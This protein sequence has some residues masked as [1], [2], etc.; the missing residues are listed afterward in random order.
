L[1]FFGSCF[2]FWISVLPFVVSRMRARVG[3]VVG[4]VRLCCVRGGTWDM[5]VCIVFVISLMGW[6]FDQCVRGLGGV[7][8]LDIILD[9]YIYNNI[10][11]F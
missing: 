7:E 6:L 10:T 11:Y 5:R 1:H 4:P 3:T 8:F 9:L 2:K